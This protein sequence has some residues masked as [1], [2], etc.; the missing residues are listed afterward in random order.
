MSNNQPGWDQYSALVLKQLESLGTG[1][2]GLRTELQE[3]KQELVEI[4]AKG[5]SDVDRIK[6]LREWKEKVDDVASPSQLKTAVNDVAE[7]KTFKTKAVTV[8]AVVQF[9]MATALALASYL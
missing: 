2:E 9:A 3:V 4:K 5:A 6:E 8:F 7:L 1:I